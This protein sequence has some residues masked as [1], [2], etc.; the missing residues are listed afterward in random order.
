MFAVDHAATAL[1]IKRRYPSVPLAP[2]LIAVQA[3]E[4]AWVVLNFL[5]VERT[6][7]E[8]VVRSVADIHLAH[9]PYSHS[10]ATALGAALL[11]WAIAELGAGRRA[12]GRAL[13]IGVASHLVLDLLTHAHDIVLRP[14]LAT[15]RLGLGL[16]DAVPT[17]AFLVELAYGVA[18][19]R[20]YRGGRG[21]LA[22]VVLG[23]LANLSL[24][25]SAIPGPEALLAGRP[26]MVVS[27]VAVQIVATLVLTGVLARRSPHGAHPGRHPERSEGSAPRARYRYGEAMTA[28]DRD[29]DRP[30]S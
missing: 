17:A 6:A 4:L 29:R 21:L 12:L 8:P 2:L 28:P 23:N 11:V 14:G 3:M 20:I 10:V 30:R 19:W 26:L 24:L 15:P 18:C 13:G 27:L 7:T 22:L 16:Y 5:G 9:M 1:L 25:S